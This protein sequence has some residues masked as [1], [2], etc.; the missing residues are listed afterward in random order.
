MVDLGHDSRAL[1]RPRDQLIATI[2]ARQHGVIARSQLVELGLGRGQSTTGWR[3]DACIEFIE[4]STP[5][6]ID[7]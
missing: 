5:S 7:G 1:D 3:S 4:P 6:A 2:A